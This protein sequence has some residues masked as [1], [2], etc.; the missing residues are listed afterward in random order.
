M[1]VV[2]LVLPG[3]IAIWY[4]LAGITSGE[5]GKRN[6]ICN[7]WLRFSNPG[8]GTCGKCGLPW[9]HCEAKII[10]WSE[11]MGTFALCDHCW[12]DSSLA[13]RK[14]YYWD[15]YFNQVALGM[16]DDH[17][18]ELMHAIEKESNETN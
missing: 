17:L 14:R 16:E 12:N 5:W 13:E 3:A 6:D 4:L 8:Y 2:I 10:D 7:I 1:K 9:N 11:S 18:C 15:C